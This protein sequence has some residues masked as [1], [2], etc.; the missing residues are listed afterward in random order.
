MSDNTDTIS[1]DNLERRCPRLGSAIPFKYCM[2]SGEDSLPC[3]KIRDCWWEIFD[4]DAYLK[5]NVP[6]PVYKQLVAAKPKEKVA[7]LLEII[8]QAKNRTRT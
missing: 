7:S 5:A 3:W 6:E 8:E 1:N 2:I 4:V